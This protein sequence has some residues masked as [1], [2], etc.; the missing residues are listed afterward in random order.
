MEHLILQYSQHFGYVGIFVFLLWCGVGFPL[1]E[2]VILITAG[3]L[4]YEE[5]LTFH[6]T[7]LVAIAG[8]LIGDIFIF[9]IGKKFGLDV[10]NHRRFRKILSEKR[11]VMIEKLFNRYGTPIVFIGRFTA[12]IRAPIFLSSGAL[13]VRFSTFLFYDSL[14]AIIS[15]PFFVWVGYYF[16]EEIEIG[17][18]CIRQAEY[19]ITAGILFAVLYLI[20][21]H[22]NRKKRAEEERTRNAEAEKAAADKAS[23]E[24]PSSGLK[25][26]QI[27]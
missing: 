25:E 18:R 1:P 12:F 27:S 9:Y 17:V 6:W 21:I 22:R 7:I 24:K 20:R 3:F 23:L 14:A 4:V 8:V 5:I 19:L 2:D 13:G 11:L 26:T 16:G 15:V 10:L